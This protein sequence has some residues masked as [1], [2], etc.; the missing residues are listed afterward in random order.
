[1]STTIT[2][3]VVSAGGS[4]AS[5]VTTGSS[6][7]SSVYA[8]TRN[9]DGFSGDVRLT[10]GKWLRGSPAV[11]IV[12]RVLRTPRGKFLP[13]PTFGVDYSILDKRRPNIQAAWKNAVEAGLA[14]LT[15]GTPPRITSLLVT[16]DPPKTNRLIYEVTFVDPRGSTK[17][18][19]KLRVVQI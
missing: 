5:T 1:M 8:V 12:V 3:S 15:K 19:N 2:W 13:D 6:T 7:R 4:S 11:E 10:S 9:L 14:F 16:V 18:V 17:D